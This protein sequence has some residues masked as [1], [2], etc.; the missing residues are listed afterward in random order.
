MGWCRKKV[1]MSAK[2][3]QYQIPL[4]IFEKILGTVH[5]HFVSFLTERNSIHLFKKS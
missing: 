2:L 4:D 5:N 3:G 1:L